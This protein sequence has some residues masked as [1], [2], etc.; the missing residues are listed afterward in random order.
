MIARD[1]MTSQVASV[2]P[3]APIRDVADVLA[4]YR[5]SG[6]PVVDEQGQ[7]LGLVT[8][9]DLISKQG[10][11]AADIMSPRVVTVREMTP[12][13]EVAQ[14]LTSNR[15]KRVPVMRDER[16]VGIVSRADIVRMMASRWVCAVCGGIEHGRRP[17]DCPTCGADGSHFDRELDPRPEVSQ[18]Q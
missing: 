5:I 17:A 4:E 13:D 14:I 18:H 7:M 6:V 9:A 2:S 8:E 15:F 3:S 11:T 16:L 10:K 12:V 1:I